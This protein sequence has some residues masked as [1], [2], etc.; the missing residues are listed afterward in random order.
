MR[1]FVSGRSGFVGHYVVPELLRR[2]CTIVDNLAMAD[3]VI[4]LAWAGL[5]NYESPLHFGNIGWQLEFLK[6]ALDCGIQNI[7]VTGTCLETLDKLMPYSIAK[8]ALRARAFELLPEIKWA[9]L[10]YL[11]GEGQNENCL[12]P[13]LYKAKRLNEPEFSI[14]D[15]ERDFVDVADAAEHIC[16]IAMQEKVTGIIDC[17]TGVAESVELFCKRRVPNIKC[18]TDFPRPYYEPFSFHGDPT[19]LLS[20]L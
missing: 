3:A 2:G 4:H 20:I 10:W 18:R 9:R 13:R 12:L 8:L 14:I 19:K 1:V 7:T 11:Y 16:A 5:P 15:G 6:E 17:C